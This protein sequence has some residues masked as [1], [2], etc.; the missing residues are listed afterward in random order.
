MGKEKLTRRTLIGSA[1]LAGLNGCGEQDTKPKASTTAQTDG[2][3]LNIIFH[4]VMVYWVGKTSMTVYLPKSQKTGHTAVHEYLVQW[5]GRSRTEILKPGGV[6]NW[7]G[8]PSGSKP[9]PVQLRNLVLE[10]LDVQPA[11]VN[12]TFQLP[13]PTTVEEF[14]HSVPPQ[15]VF[16]SGTLP[17]GVANPVAL[18]FP[19]VF[20]YK[21]P[22]SAL[23]LSFVNDKNQPVSIAAYSNGDPV[24]IHIHADPPRCAPDAD[25]IFINNEA[26]SL[27]GQ[28][29]ALAYADRKAMKASPLN[30]SDRRLARLG[31]DPTDLL[32]K[33][34]FPAVC[35]A[36]LPPDSCFG[37]WV[38]E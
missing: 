19:I 11:N 18:A 16:A 31:L 8:L 12:M 6:F 24:N 36:T 9:A 27:G 30:S 26:I 35:P 21:N 38:I 2:A 7:T 37:M 5:A 20:S 3:R 28:P 25:H 10:G 4:G 22:N 13:Y 34:E 32:E 17:T 14:R 23:K 29:L 1:A 15:Y 33:I